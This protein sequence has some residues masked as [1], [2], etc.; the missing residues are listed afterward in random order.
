MLLYQ[1]HLRHI[2]NAQCFFPQ[3][4]VLLYLSLPE[5]PGIARANKKIM[6]HF[7]SPFSSIHLW[8]ASW[9][10]VWYYWISLLRPGVIHCMKRYRL[11]HSI[12]GIKCIKPFMLCCKWYLFMQCIASGKWG[13]CG[14][15][16]WRGRGTR[17]YNIIRH[18][19]CQASVIVKVFFL[20]Y[21]F[22]FIL[23][24]LLLLLLFLVHVKILHV[25][26]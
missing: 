13:V 20:F 1:F 24:F 10:K 26:L 12:K 4:L 18:N 23:F 3:S 22:Y 5:V 15:G 14:G 17:K 11:Q 2:L 6:I 8:C 16:G 7:V 25:W 9:G 19:I 21:F